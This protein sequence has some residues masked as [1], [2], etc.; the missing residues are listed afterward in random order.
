MTSPITFGSETTETFSGTVTGQSGDG[1]PEGTV[2]VYYGTPTATQLCHEHPHR[3]RRRRGDLQLCAD[4]QPA[5]VGTYTSV[6]AVFAPGGTSSSN[7]D[8]TYTGSTSTPDPELHGQ[9]GIGEHHDQPQRRD[10]ADHLGSETTET[11]TGTVTG[12][13]GDGYPEGTVSVYER[14]PDRAVQRDPAGRQRRRRHLQLL[15][16][17]RHRAGR[18]GHALP[19]VDAIFTP[20]GTSSSNADFTYTDLDLDPG[21]EPHGEPRVREHHDQPQ[22]RDLADH[23]GAE[24]PPRPSPAR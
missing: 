10:L 5:D 2:N 7:L 9:P 6:D 14:H 15:P 11:F 3:E 17:E 13:S 8:F 23:L 12:Q 20:G 1:N 22:R 24:R 19:S 16:D 18:L 4:R 21:P